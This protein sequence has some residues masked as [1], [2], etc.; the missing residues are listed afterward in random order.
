M[1]HEYQL[2]KTPTY[3]NMKTG[4]S[5]L[6]DYVASIQKNTLLLTIWLQPIINNIL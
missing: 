6:P 4:A 1:A 3:L 2:S 5:Y